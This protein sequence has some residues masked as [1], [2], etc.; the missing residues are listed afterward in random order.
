MSHQ[1]RKLKKGIVM[2]VKKAK[3]SIVKAKPNEKKWNSPSDDSLETAIADFDSGI[4]PH[5]RMDNIV[6]VGNNQ[7]E[8]KPIGKLSSLL[9]FTDMHSHLFNSND[10]E[11]KIQ[12]M[13]KAEYVIINKT[14]W[15]LAAGSKLNYNAHDVRTCYAEEGD[16]GVGDLNI[17]YLHGSHLNF[18]NFEESR[19]KT[20]NFLFAT[21][22]TTN[23]LKLDSCAI[24]LSIF[25][26]TFVEIKNSVVKDISI[27]ASKISIKDTKMQSHHMNTHGEVHLERYRTSLSSTGVR[28]RTFPSM[29]NN[30]V[31]CPNHHLVRNEFVI[32]HV[33]KNVGEKFDINII[34]RVDYGVFNGVTP[35]NF[36]RANRCDLLL[37]GFYITSSTLDIVYDRFQNDIHNNGNAYG[38]QKISDETYLENI[39]ALREKAVGDGQ[40]ARY[41]PDSTN[42]IENGLILG[43]IEQMRS[44]SNLY[45]QLDFLTDKYN[46]IS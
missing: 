23:T 7:I 8:L 44:R 18:Y 13:E 14:I 15:V 12:A 25:K 29:V 37:D 9:G 34:S 5:T 30:V 20:V 11:D 41:I 3:P 46:S 42:R 45:K 36:V 31:I 19:V 38:C 27:G 17:V 2:S 32:P 40:S 35:V 24:F 1:L 10:A 22:I 33:F 16:V 6:I 21:Q 4:S 43:F 28:M 26:A 39:R